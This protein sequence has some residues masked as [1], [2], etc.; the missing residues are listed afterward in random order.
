MT[1]PNPDPELITWALDGP[2]RAS[3]RIDTTKIEFHLSD[4]DS[5]LDVHE[6]L[7]R[8]REA[9]YQL[10]IALRKEYKP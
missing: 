5:I 9:V 7:S 2:G 3:L 4:E 10:G 8:I 1:N 6:C